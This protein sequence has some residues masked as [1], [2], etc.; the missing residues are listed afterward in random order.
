MDILCPECRKIKQVRCFRYEYSSLAHR[1]SRKKIRTICNACFIVALRSK[2]DE[3]AVATA[4]ARNEINAVT[5]HC[6]L[7]DVRAAKQQRYDAGKKRM[8]E[9]AKKQHE[10]R[11]ML[12]DVYGIRS[13]DKTERQ[14]FMHNPQAGAAFDKDM[15]TRTAR[16]RMD[17]AVEEARR[18]KISDSLKAYN[19]A[20]K[21]E[22]TEF[23]KEEPS[24]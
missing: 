14:H 16:Y 15:A 11:R 23:T 7:N 10:K 20:R 21:E 19:T 18:K 12:R 22:P 8:S 13:P 2:G 6:I 9:S 4:L 3:R 24:Q 17:V 5:A 1:V